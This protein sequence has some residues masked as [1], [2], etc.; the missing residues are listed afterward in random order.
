MTSTQ[1]SRTIGSW[2]DLAR[3]AETSAKGRWVFRGEPKAG[4]PLLPKAGRVG[5]YPGAARRVPYRVQEKEGALKAFKRQ[6]PPYL[7]HAPANDVE[8]LA[9]ARHHGLPTRLLDWTES[10]LVAAYFAV[11]EAG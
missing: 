7:G 10:L 9:I 8:R 5:S 2:M 4:N 11:E 1:N 6:A 3:L